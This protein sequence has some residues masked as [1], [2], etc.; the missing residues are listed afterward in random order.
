MKVMVWIVCFG[1]LHV[2]LDFINI[3]VLVALV[4]IIA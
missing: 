3:V 2:E 1:W 4:V